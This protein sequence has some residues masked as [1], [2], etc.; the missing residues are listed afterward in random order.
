MKKKA[1]ATKMAA[2][3]M[4]GAMTMA[5]GF[6]AF[7]KDRTSSTIP[8]WKTVN[9]GT[10]QANIYAPK[11][12]FNFV[13]GVPDT[14]TNLRY[15]GNTYYVK[16]AD[17][18]HI[19]FVDASGAITAGQI[20]FD[21]A[22]D[23]FTNSKSG[24][25]IK[26]DFARIYAEEGAGIYQYTVKEE[27]P[28]TGYEGMGYDN[29][30]YNI[31]AFV[32]EDDTA[33][34]IVVEK[35]GKLLSDNVTKE[36]ESKKFEKVEFVNDYDVHTLTITKTVTGN[37]GEKNRGFEFKFKVTGNVAGEKFKW[38]AYDKNGNPVEGESGSGAVGTETTV[39]LKDGESVKIYGLSSTD[40]YSVSESDY[41]TNDGYKTKVDGTVVEGNKKEGTIT[42]DIT[43]AYVN[44]RGITTPTG[45]VTEYAP[46]ILLVAAAGAFAVLFL[47]RKKEEF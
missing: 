45:I 34:A 29:S 16:K 30:T 25:N 32:Y 23:A 3:V 5:M 1:L 39:Q 38:I 18:K 44:D 15:D 31:Y 7:A 4:A 2:F 13:L 22:T 36:N 35:D 12:T 19:S 11:T 6:P 17:I 43:V 21:P 20:E 37:Q 14:T 26:V 27:T 10:E 40:G 42:T 8:V 28:T 46:Y 9:A 33:D 47:R 24:L 41:T